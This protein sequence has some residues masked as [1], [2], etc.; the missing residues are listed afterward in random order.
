[1]ISNVMA[2]GFIT[3]KF[4]KNYVGLKIV[5]LSSIQPHRGNKNNSNKSAGDVLGSANA[6]NGGEVCSTDRP[7]LKNRGIGPSRI[8]VKADKMDN[9]FSMI[10]AM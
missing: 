3:Q 5:S 6:G 8:W 7:D 1:M 2:S 9:K 10:E 4:K